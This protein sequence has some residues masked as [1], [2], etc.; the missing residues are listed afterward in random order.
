[1]TTWRNPNFMRRRQMRLMAEEQQRLVLRL[2]RQQL[3]A[4]ADGL[5]EI[6]QHLAQE[7]AAL[8][9][10][11]SALDAALDATA[12]FDGQADALRKHLH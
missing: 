3:R 2:Q 10:H 1:M 6:A 12:A 4:A 11:Q 5:A 7:L 8:P 9:A